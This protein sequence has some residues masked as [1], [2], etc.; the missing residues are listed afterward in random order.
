MYIVNF[1][2]MHA[3]TYVLAFSSCGSMLTMLPFPSKAVSNSDKLGNKHFN[4]ID[5]PVIF[6]YF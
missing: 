4:E 5:G 3:C 6:L 1:F 2:S